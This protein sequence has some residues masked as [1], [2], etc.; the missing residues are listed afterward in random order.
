MM[1]AKVT[2]HH[3][4]SSFMLFRA[5]IK[6]SSSTCFHMQLNKFTDYGL[7]ILMTVAH[8]RE[9]PY[10]IAELAKQLHVSENHLV[11]IVHFMA[12][13][14]WLITTRGK[15]GGIRFNPQV[16][17][18]HLGD[19]VRIL[20]GEVD[21]VECHNP[22]CVLRVQCGLKGILNQAVNTFYLQLNQYKIA[23]VLQLNPQTSPNKNAIPL[24]NLSS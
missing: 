8:D 7:R 19:V 14:N 3:L 15:G 9:M 1:F 13:Q 23:D 10:T 2:A 21:I 6:T 16:M 20:Q 12:K 18:A 4:V 22:P 5:N 17:Q 24:L 11:K